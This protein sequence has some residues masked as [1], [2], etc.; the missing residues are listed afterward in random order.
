MLI[1]CEKRLHKGVGAGVIVHSLEAGS[2]K[3]QISCVCLVKYIVGTSDS[4]GIN[5]PIILTQT[6]YIL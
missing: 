4:V 1:Q 6:L 5:K 2:H 3:V